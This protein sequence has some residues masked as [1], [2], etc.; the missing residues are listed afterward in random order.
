MNATLQY[1]QHHLVNASMGGAVF[2]LY[3]MSHQMWFV[4]L[5]WYRKY[6]V[7][8]KFFALIRF[9]SLIEH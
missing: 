5:Q 2:G 9:F 6:L 7:I 8:L 3:Y 1:T 4:W